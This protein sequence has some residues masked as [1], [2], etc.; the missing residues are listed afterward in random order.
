MCLYF[1]QDFAFYEESRFALKG[2]GCM[3]VMEPLFDLIRGLA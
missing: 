1:L 3:G 2:I